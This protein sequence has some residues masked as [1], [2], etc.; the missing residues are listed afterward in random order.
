MQKALLLV[1]DVETRRNSTYLMLKRLENLK[2]SVKSYQANNNKFKPENILTADKW[3]VVSL[4]IEL[5]KP[6]YIVTRQCS[7]NNASLSSVI[8]RAAALK[9]FFYRKT[10]SNLIESLWK[11]L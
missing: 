7:K 6:I 2:L 9:R 1:Q 11:A 10:N 3:K 8:R 4:L 5:L